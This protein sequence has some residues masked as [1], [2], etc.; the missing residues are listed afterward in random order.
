MLIIAS[1]HVVF[2]IKLQLV[3]L[4]L[5]NAINKQGNLMAED[6]RSHYLK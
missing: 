1:E 3:G 5:F 4:K 2:L 6:L